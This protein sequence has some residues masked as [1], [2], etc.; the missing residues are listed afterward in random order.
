MINESD[1][2]F[3]PYSRTTEYHVDGSPRIPRVT[4]DCSVEKIDLAVYA[5]NFM[6]HP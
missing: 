5:A 3:M 1:N 2:H 4:F 6:H